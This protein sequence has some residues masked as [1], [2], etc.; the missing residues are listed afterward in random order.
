MVSVGA[1]L[2]GRPMSK[3]ANMRSQMPKV[4]A[5]IDELRA[6]FGADDIN[7]GLRFKMPGQPVFHASEAGHSVGTPYQERGTE[8]SVAQMVIQRP[9]GKAAT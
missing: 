3:P 2:R 4:A 7:A 9:T 1:R 6:A 8:I 5:W